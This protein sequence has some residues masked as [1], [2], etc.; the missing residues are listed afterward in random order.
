MGPPKGVQTGQGP[1]VDWV[2]ERGGT[3]GLA[4]PNWAHRRP[5]ANRILELNMGATVVVPLLKWVDQ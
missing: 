4:S 2:R 5:V 1:L 3:F